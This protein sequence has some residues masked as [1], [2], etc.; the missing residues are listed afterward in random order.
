M[1]KKRTGTTQAAKSKSGRCRSVIRRYFER[2][3]CWFYLELSRWGNRRPLIA[4]PVNE[5]FKQLRHGVRQSNQRKNSWLS[6]CAER[7]KH[8]VREISSNT[9]SSRY[10][11]QIFADS[12]NGVQYCGVVS[13]T[14]CVLPGNGAFPVRAKVPRVDL[15]NVINRFRCP[16][17][18]MRPIGAYTTTINPW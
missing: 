16:V 14:I 11:L 3:S 1:E 12:D 17:P 6:E 7:D 8:F 18:K 5:A 13:R 2:L 4:T 10:W 9:V 15:I